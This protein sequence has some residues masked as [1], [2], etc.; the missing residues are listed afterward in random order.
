MNIQGLAYLF[1]L[2]FF[3]VVSMDNAKS[4]TFAK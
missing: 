3:I 4:P 2:C 1:H